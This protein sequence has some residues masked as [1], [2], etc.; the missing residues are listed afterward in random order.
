MAAD[1][2]G[3][4]AEKCSNFCRNHV[5]E[6]AAACRVVSLENRGIISIDRDP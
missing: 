5:F 3:E 1:F 2:G 4:E 6:A